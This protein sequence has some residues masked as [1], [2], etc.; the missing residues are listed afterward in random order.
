MNII[1]IE[2]NFLPDTKPNLL[3]VLNT[4]NTKMPVTNLCNEYLHIDGTL[5]VAAHRQYT[6]RT[7]THTVHST[8]LHT[9]STTHVPLHREY[10]A[11]IL[12]PE[13]Q[14]TYLQHRQYTVRTSTQ[15]VL[16]TYLHTDSTLHV[17][18]HNNARTFTQT[19]HC[20]YLH[21]QYTARTFT[22]ILHCMYLHTDSTLHVH[23]Y[24]QYNSRTFMQTLHST[25][26]F[27]RIWN[28]HWKGGDFRTK[29]RLMWIR[30]DSWWRFRKRTFKTTLKSKRNDG[31]S[32][33][34]PKG[35]TLK[36]NEVP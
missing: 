12:T 27:S 7:F 19:V 18:S 15:T 6:A 34:G 4:V 11:C 32:V 23:S 8:S 14:C 29:T 36:G 35:S 26:G 2:R 25:S 28:W 16:C 31:I 21:T 10:T 1:L 3:L 20:T 5:H 17:P 30:W 13:V 22:Q 24:G 9:D 33:R